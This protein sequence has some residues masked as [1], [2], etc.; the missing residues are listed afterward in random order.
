LVTVPDA[1]VYAP[2]LT[3]YVPPAV[4]DIG[5]AALI[6]DTVIVFDVTT[7]LSATPVWS[8]KVNGLGVVSVADRVVTLKVSLTPPMVSVAFTVVE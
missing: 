1:L 4:I 6:P 5:D 3:E 2:P 7:V 8:V